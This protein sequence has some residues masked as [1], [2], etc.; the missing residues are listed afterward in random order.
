MR[1]RALRADLGH[2]RRSEA[3]GKG[4]LE[5][6]GHLL[7]AKHQNGM[8]LEGRAHRCIG[9]IVGGD[10]GKPDATQFRAESRTQRH[11]VHRRAPL[12]FI[13]ERYGKSAGAATRGPMTRPRSSAG[14]AS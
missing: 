6:V 3:A 13:V 11:D 5:F 7:A 8:F 4:E 14:S 12:L 1:T 2:L 9:G 10:I